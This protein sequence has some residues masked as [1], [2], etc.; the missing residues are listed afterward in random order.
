M[1][2]LTKWD[3]LK[4]SPSWDPFREMEEMQR[5]RWSLFGRSLPGW[6]SEPEEGFTL[7]EW[8]PPVDIEIAV[9]PKVL[10]LEPIPASRLG[11]RMPPV[12]DRAGIAGF[13][14][15]LNL[16]SE[17]GSDRTEKQQEKGG[18]R[19]GQ[20]GRDRQDRRFDKSAC[21]NGCVKN[22]EEHRISAGHSKRNFEQIAPTNC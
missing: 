11:N 16:G 20:P 13:E 7:A 5:R 6:R 1:N 3:P 14:R 8:M 12:P 19:F 15:G 17:P 4:L 22:R 9:G 21:G 2:K 18:V 10:T